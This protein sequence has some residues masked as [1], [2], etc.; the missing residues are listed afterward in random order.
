MIPPFPPPSVSSFAFLLAACVFSGGAFASAASE[1]IRLAFPPDRVVGWLYVRASGSEGE[2]RNAGGGAARTPATGEIALPPGLEARLEIAPTELDDLS[3]L[4]ALAPDALRSL[5][6]RGFFEF[7]RRWAL[8]DAGAAWIGRLTGLRDL[9]IEGGAIGDAGLAGLAPLKELR[10]LELD[11]CNGI[12]DAGLI[13]LKDA[14]A[15]ET[16]VLGSTAIRGPG[17]AHLAKLDRLRDLTLGNYLAPSNA[18]DDSVF[19][20]LEDFDWLDAL[21][22]SGCDRVTD[23][24][25]AGFAKLRDL[26]LLQIWNCRRVTDASIPTLT[27]AK[28][29]VGLD[30]VGTGITETGMK[31]LKAGLPGCVLRHAYPGAVSPSPTPRERGPIS[32]AFGRAERDGA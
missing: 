11:D 13:A 15:I 2:W 28:G 9:R 3:F 10:S 4:A 32:S 21:N 25:L 17:L 23:R 1:G 14:V 26:A 22:L 31:S 8:D 19:P 18:L 5:E 16:L 20:H 12:G 27:A 24:G 7:S 29:L 6:C 30:I